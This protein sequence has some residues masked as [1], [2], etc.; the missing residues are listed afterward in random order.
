MCFQASSAWPVMSAGSTPV[1]S[2]PGVPEVKS[3]RMLG[4]VSTA[5]LYL[6]IWFAMPM[7]WVCGAWGVLLLQSVLYFEFYSRGLG[8][9]FLGMTVM[10]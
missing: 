2:R 3:Q 9:E 4:A 10:P 5:S 7:L 8:A 1:V 6:P